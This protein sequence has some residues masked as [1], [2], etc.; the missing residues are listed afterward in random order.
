PLCLEENIA[1]TPYSSLASGRL[2]RLPDIQSK[3]LKED[4]YA[5]TKYDSTNNEDNKI[6]ERVHEL[7]NKY[8]VSM[9]EISLSWLESKVTSPIVGATKKNHVDGAVNSVELDL[10]EEDLYYL[11][12]LYVPHKLVGVMADNKEKN[13]EDKKVWMKHTKNKL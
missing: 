8:D 10:S 3:R 9:T 6:I 4:L 13:N 5:K 11:E 1:T 2:S 12:Q 7:A